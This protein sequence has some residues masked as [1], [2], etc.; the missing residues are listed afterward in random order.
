[1][2]LAKRTY[3][4][5][6]DTIEAF[7]REVASGER[8]AVVTDLIREW[9]EERRKEELRKSIIEGCKEM[10]DIYLET[11]REF[12]PLEEEVDHLLHGDTSEG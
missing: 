5:P 7:E 6:A 4:L 3:A 9:L 10:W 11:E 1:M 8:S 12:H 2:A